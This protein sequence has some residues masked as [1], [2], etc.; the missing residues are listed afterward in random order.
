[1]GMGCNEGCP[2]VLWLTGERGLLF[3]CARNMGNDDEYDVVAA[4]VAAADDDDCENDNI[5]L[6]RV[7]ISKSFFPCCLRSE[8]G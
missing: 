2:V 6:S 3:K 1:M 8:E 5:L 4:A 7:N